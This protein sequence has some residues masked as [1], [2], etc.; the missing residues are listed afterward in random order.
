MEDE[1]L[2]G[3]ARV[4]CREQNLDDQIA[5]LNS[6]GCVKVYSEKESGARAD[7]PQL[8]KAIAA[9]A[10]GDVLIVTRLDRLARSTRDL[11]NTLATISEHGANFKSL[12]DVWADTTSAHG[13]L[14]VTLLGGIAEFERS[15]IKARCDAGIARAREAGVRFGRKPKLTSHQR[16]QALALRASGEPHAAIARTFAVHQSTITRLA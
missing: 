6:A 9:L 3:Y 4:S 5:A 8:A 16:Q 14:M 13:Q 15:L 1:M 11:L 12:A 7:R 2:I 10:S